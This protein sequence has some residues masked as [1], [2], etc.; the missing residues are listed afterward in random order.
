MRAR[1]RRQTPRPGAIV[2]IDPVRIE[3]R[4]A[5]QPAFEAERDG[6]RCELPELHVQI[7]GPPVPWQRAR[8][9]KDGGFAN[10]PEARAYKR[11][12]RSCVQATL[13]QHGREWPLDGQY[14]LQVG[15]FFPDKRTRDDDNVEKALKD[16]CS[17][18]LWSD[19]NWTRF[20][21]ITKTMELDRE[22][23]RVEMTV[24][25]VA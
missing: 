6:E 4:P 8:P 2:E 17:G 25:V 5:S 21:R 20:R 13:M 9:R 23:P 12:V 10:T 7:P 1:A 19:D 22:R 3:P 15:M 16:A 14:E 18:V 11:H 24:K